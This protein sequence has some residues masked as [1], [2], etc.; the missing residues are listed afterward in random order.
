MSLLDYLGGYEALRRNRG[1]RGRES[2]RAHGREREAQ[3]GGRDSSGRRGGQ[4]GRREEAIRGG[5][6]ERAGISVGSCLGGGDLLLVAML[7][8]PKN[9]V[10]E[11]KSLQ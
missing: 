5:R 11:R 6:G 7:P 2:K 9:R 1:D 10:P 4:G 3:S 8:F